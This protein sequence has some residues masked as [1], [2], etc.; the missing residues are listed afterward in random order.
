MRK[1]LFIAGLLFFRADAQVVQWASKVLEYSSQLTPIQYS[2]N[3]VLGKPS[4]LPGGGLNPGAWMPD[5]PGRNEFIKVAFEKPMVIQQVAVAES[6]NPGALYRIT[7][8]D[9]QGNAHEFETLNP[10]VV[11]LKSRMRNV[12]SDLTTFKVTAVKLE[13]DGSILTDHFAIDA[14]GIS[15][16]NYPIIPNIPQAEAVA[17]GIIIESLDKNVNSEVKELNP[18]LSPD[19]KT[20]YFSRQFHPENTGGVKDKEDIWYSNLDEQGN[21]QLA[22]NM[23]PQFNNEAPNFIN[24]ILSAT[25][26]GK[27]MVMVLG[28][29]VEGKKVLAGV[30]I[31]SNVGGQ[32]TK[33]KAL[34]ITNDYNMSEYANYFLTNNRITMLM[35]KQRAD[36]HGDRDL[37]VS[38]MRSDSVWTE[39][40]NL[41]GIVNTIADDVSPFLA[42]DDKTLYYSSKGMSGFGGFD[43]YMSKRLDD[44]WTNW[45]VPENMGKQINSA[46]DDLYFNLPGASEYSYYSRG[47]DENNTDIFQAKLPPQLSPETFA[48]VKGKLMDAKTDLPMGATIVY[49]RLSDGKRLGIFDADPKTGEFDLKL[50]MGYHYGIHAE[51]KNYISESQNIDLRNLRR[52]KNVAVEFRLRPIQVVTIEKEAVVRLNNVFFDFNMAVLKSESFPELDRVVAMMNERPGLTIE[53]AG[54]TDNIGTANYNQKLSEKRSDAVKAYLITKGINAVRI[55]TIGFGESKPIVSN[56]D[57]KDGREINRRVEFRIVKTE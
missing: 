47:V 17:A 52:E 2:A 42:I 23:G 35:S 9:E 19:G 28:N 21:W 32:W 3:Q 20:M 54:H 12:F 45:S 49:E 57:E 33:P 4:V 56:D 46:F 37:Y 44:S 38:F 36:T 34:A 51:A 15:D 16:S 31:S 1:L 53:V 39:P 8:F 50:P 29:R 6:F 14:I 26:D 22:K 30:S 11:P 40:K 18:L 24:T 7:V 55:T 25:P 43:V 48:T 5:K 27:S 41:G 13:F 10:M